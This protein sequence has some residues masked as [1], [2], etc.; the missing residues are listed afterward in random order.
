LGNDFLGLIS[1]LSVFGVLDVLV[2]TDSDLLVVLGL[3]LLSSGVLFGLFVLGDGDSLVEGGDFGFEVS[4]LGVDVVQL[5]FETLS[6][7]LV[8]MDPMLVG[9]SLD[10]SGLG[11]LVEELVTD[12]D[13]LLDSGAGS[14]DGGGSG[15]L[16][17]E[18]E[19]RV[20]GL[21]GEL[22]LLG[23]LLE[24]LGDLDEGLSGGLGTGLLEERTG[25]QSLLDNFLRSL[26]DV[27]S[28]VVFLDFL[29][30]FFVSLGLGGIQI[31]DL[32]V[33][34]VSELLLVLEELNLLVSDGDLLFEF[35]LEFLGSLLGV[36]NL[37]LELGDLV[38]TSLLD[39]FDVG[40]ISIL[41]SFD[42]VLN[43]LEHVDQILDR[44]TGLELKLDGVQQGLT[45]SGHLDLLEGLVGIVFTL[46]LTDDAHG[47]ASDE[48]NVD[49]SH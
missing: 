17:K 33:Q 21:S 30:P 29:S 37:L 6:G 5:V 45:E 39:L 10:F 19:D 14:L 4:D 27:L 23:G 22:N 47:E 32:L 25:G 15:D 1:L 41:F 46:L 11:N 13:D 35:G 3:L 18:L 12:G 9:S 49:K 36:G 38:V 26:D 20:P 40:I 7:D 34:E 42:V 28:L 16:G 44:V 2:V 24:V 48:S 43:V 31:V 8:L